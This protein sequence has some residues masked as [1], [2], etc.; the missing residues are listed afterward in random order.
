MKEDVVT[1]I[2]EDVVTEIKVLYV[3][4]D[5]QES[6]ISVKIIKVNLLFFVFCRSYLFLF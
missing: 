5:I 2:K 6:D 4:K 3:L 1:E